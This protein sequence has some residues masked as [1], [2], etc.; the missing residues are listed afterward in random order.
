MWILHHPPLAIVSHTS[1]KLIVSTLLSHSALGEQACQA[2][3]NWG[4]LIREL[5]PSCWC[6]WRLWILELATACTVCTG[7]KTLQVCFLWLQVKWQMIWVFCHFYISTFK[8]SERSSKILNPV[9]SQ[10]SRILLPWKANILKNKWMNNTFSVIKMHA[11][12]CPE[13]I[14]RFHRAR[15]RLWLMDGFG[16]CL[17]NMLLSLLCCHIVL[18]V[19]RGSD[20]ERISRAVL[21][22]QSISVEKSVDHC[23]SSECS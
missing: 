10:L 23:L 18:N 13:N 22:L 4:I 17:I 2:W 15:E 14:E 6:S 12:G 5:Q 3:I 9:V 16:C 1:N 8:S 11:L 20:N 7:G 21:V 19:N